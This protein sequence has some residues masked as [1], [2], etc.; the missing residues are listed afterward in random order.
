[1]GLSFSIWYPLEYLRGSRQHRPW[2][3]FSS[4]AMK[5]PAKP[6]I[7]PGGFERWKQLY[8]VLIHS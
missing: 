8:L 3:S 4:Y 2:A 5:N 1:M 6:K 7:L